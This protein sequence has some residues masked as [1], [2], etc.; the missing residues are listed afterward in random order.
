METKVEVRTQNAFE[1]LGI[2]PTKKS[3]Q[4]KNAYRAQMLALQLK[5]D[6]CAEAEKKDI[7]PEF[8]LLANA[9]GKI[10]TKTKL[11]EYYQHCVNDTLTDE[12]RPKASRYDDT[13]SLADKLIIYIPVFFNGVK[14]NELE[15]FRKQQAKLLKKGEAASLGLPI[16]AKNES[17]IEACPIQSF[18]KDFFIYLASHLQKNSCR[19]GL[20]ARDA[21]NTMDF[22]TYAECPQTALIVTASV[23]RSHLLNNTIE[24]TKQNNTVEKNVYIKLHDNN[25]ICAESILTIQHLNSIKPRNTDN[26]RSGAESKEGCIWPSQSICLN[27]FFIPQTSDEGSLLDQL[28]NDLRDPDIQDKP[29]K[30][31]QFIESLAEADFDL[32]QRAK[33]PAH[34]HLAT[35]TVS[36]FFKNI[37]TKAKILTANSQHLLKPGKQEVN[38]TPISASLRDDLR[39]T[40]K[41]SDIVLSS[42]ESTRKKWATEGLLTFIECRDDIESLKNEM[43]TFN[44]LHLANNDS[45]HR[46][47]FEDIL[48]N[49][50]NLITAE[51]QALASTKNSALT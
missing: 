1:I 15:K 13:T 35:D 22:S 49:L 19:V 21:F 36:S 5:L 24:R 51:E 42:C 20:T 39:R 10:K 23:S 37:A 3:Y 31:K 41:E 48:T 28:K 4:V 38:L 30:I 27:E 29:A 34:S 6:S 40:I 18:N 8:Q 45:D 46:Q 17:E 11:K 25:D 32:K 43:D 33:K 12:H 26:Y 14:P 9:Y 16:M 7:Q 2:K 44:T 50:K 47:L